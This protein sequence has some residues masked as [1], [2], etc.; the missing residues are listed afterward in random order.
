MTTFSSRILTLMLLSGLAACGGSDGGGTPT[1]QAPTA[2]AGADQSVDAGTDVSLSG[3]G[4]DSDGSVSAYAWTQTAGPAVTLSSTTNEAPD[5]TAPDVDAATTLTFELSVTDD[6]GT[7]ATD[8][9][10]IE[11]AP[12]VALS[13]RVYDGP[14]A[15]A[16]VTVTVGDRTYTA[17]ADADGVYTLNIGAVDPDA[18]VTISATGAEGQ[19]HVELLSVAG[20]FS[21]L[22]TAAGDDGVLEAA[23]SGNINVTNLSTAK[24]VLMIDAN[25]GE[26]ITDDSTFAT[27]EANVS[28][29]D[30][31]YLATVIKLVVDGGF[32]LPEGVDSTLEL[33][34][35]R[36]TADTFVDAVDAEDPAAFDANFDAIVSDPDL[37][38]AYT[39]DTV[40]AE[41][42][43]VFVSSVSDTSLTYRVTNRGKA[44]TFDESG[45][46]A[47]SDADYASAPFDWVVTDGK[48]VIT[49]DDP[50]LSNGY[51]SHPEQPENL[52]FYC[53]GTTTSTTITLLTDGASADNLLLS[54]TGTTTYPDDG[55]TDVPMSGG[56]TNLGLQASAAIPFT[57][58]EV[59]GRWVT[60]VSGRVSADVAA[61][62]LGLLDSG[63]LEFE[64][65]GLGERTATD[66]VSSE[67]FSW[68]VSDSGVLTIEYEGGDVVNY[69]RLRRDGGVYD[70][71]A[72]LTR[73]E[74]GRH[75]DAGLMLEVD[76]ASLPLLESEDVPGRYT[77]FEMENDFSIRFD[78]TGTGSEEQYD[79]DGPYNTYPFSWTLREDY[80]V[81][82]AYYWDGVV[83]DTAVCVDA[84]SCEL[85]K[86][87][88]WYPAA[89]DEDT[90]RVY[91]LEI[92]QRY[93]W[94]PVAALHM[95]ALDYYQ[96]SIRY[97]GRTEL[98]AAGVE[99]PG[100]PHAA[101]TNRMQSL[102]AR[103]QLNNNQ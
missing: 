59:P 62:T 99:K 98:P 61:V 41:L 29:D 95:G 88:L 10:D 89:Y 53:E 80:V 12:V 31:L 96:P 70:T 97:W 101:W 43:T 49:Y 1:N 60:A 17:T 85:Y 54:D 71:L 22:Q 52:T 40:P 57:A 44:W 36:E 26:A 55:F 15:N 51:C 103:P 9:V 11:V 5:F 65:N 100:A 93:V 86:H 45:R 75:S 64:A 63:F 42:F 7:T 94:D 58:E 46:G 47:L 27:L 25:G 66:H 23:E 87:R 6:G 19:E 91:L 81:E 14:I 16:I 68:S 78:A 102:L 37:V 21:A 38:A 83:G 24:A 39:A 20:S 33:I 67:P 48:I 77:L 32:D 73:F 8:S 4:T 79:A 76:V 3:S 30:L 72:L 74:G 50:V 34:E 35:T 82:M 92:Q 2:D 13:G 84:A 56:S 28:G 18:F 69:Y 90:G